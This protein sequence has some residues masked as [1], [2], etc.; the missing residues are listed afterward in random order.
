MHSMWKDHLR[1]L[2]GKENPVVLLL[3]V[4]I[5]RFINVQ[6]IYHKL[7]VVKLW[8]WPSTLY[9]FYFVF[10]RLSFFI[11]VWQIFILYKTI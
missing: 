9:T 2:W 4:E 8:P 5:Q 11:P 6:V 1:N 7:E 10:S 3:H